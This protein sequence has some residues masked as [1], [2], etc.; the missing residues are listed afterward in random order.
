MPISKW[1]EIILALSKLTPIPYVGL[2]A[3]LA[4]I[5]VKLLADV[6]EKT[7]LSDEQIMEKAN[8]V[9][10]LNQAMIEAEL[11]RLDTQPLPPSK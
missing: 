4:R 2:S 1:L 5:F 3:E 6:R 8:I 9:G 10:E 7:N 11:A